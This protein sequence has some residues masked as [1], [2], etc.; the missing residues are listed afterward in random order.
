MVDG[1]LPADV[2]R[3]LIR[4][5]REVR[6]RKA[7]HTSEYP[8]RWHPTGITNPL[9]GCV[10]SDAGAWDWIA[11]QLEAGI[12]AWR[13]VLDQPPGKIAWYFTVPT[14]HNSE[15]IYIKLQHCGDHVRG[16]SFHYSERRI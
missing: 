15:P 7:Q 4:F 1:T 12:D 5:S 14:P 13:L 9:T 2:R 6:R 3:D 10:F 11:E 8:S 16:R